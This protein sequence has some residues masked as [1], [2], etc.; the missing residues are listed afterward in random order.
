MLQLKLRAH[1]IAL[2]V[3]CAL[4]TFASAASS[5]PEAHRVRAALQNHGG[6]WSATL[7]LPPGTNRFSLAVMMRENFADQSV[8]VALFDSRGR[9]L[10]TAAETTAPGE[11]APTAKEGAIHVSPRFVAPLGPNPK[12]V[13]LQVRGGGSTHAPLEVMSVIA[14]LQNATR[15]QGLVDDG[16]QEMCD[17]QMPERAFARSVARLSIRTARGTMSYCTGFAIDN[18]HLVTNHHCIADLLKEPNQCQSIQIEFNYACV[19]QKV[20]IAQP[21]CD[22]VVARRSDALDY[23]VIAFKSS[24]GAIPPLVPSRIAE[25]DGTPFLLH[26]SAG[27]AMRL[28]T[29][30]KPLAPVL[31]NEKIKQKISDARAD[32]SGSIRKID[33]QF[34]EVSP[35]EQRAVITHAVNTTN[36]ASGAPVMVG[37]KVLALHFDRD[38]R[39]YPSGNMCFEASLENCLT[40]KL[41]LPNWAVRICDV[42]DDIPDSE[43]IK[44]C[45]P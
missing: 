29:T 34:L 18:N 43:G 11:Y 39:Y 3:M 8:R 33:A 27:M 19:D 13:I 45:A 17:D 20:A 16:S 37:D 35:A 2:V 5:P 21:T 4:T 44:R 26:H 7:E 36:G 1:F 25:K 38:H 24:A 40:A 10:A 30:D 22:R 28:G 31:M 6:I 41:S 15:V 32:C 42:L 14:D 9:P 23:A 12:T